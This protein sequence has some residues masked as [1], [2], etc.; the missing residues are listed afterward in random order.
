V[1]ARE[2]SFTRTLVPNS[3]LLFRYSALSFN[4]HRIHYDADYCREVEGYPD[5]VIHGPLLATLLA[6]FAEE[7]SGRPL[8][9]FSYRALRPAL[10]GDA[11]SLHADVLDTGI[12]LHATLGDGTPCMRAEAGVD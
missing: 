3:T 6:N 11:I 5:L 7:T 9:R 4:G 8:R 10:L 1:P 12:A 2:G